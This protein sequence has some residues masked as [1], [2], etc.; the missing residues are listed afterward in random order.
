MDELVYRW[1]LENESILTR[2]QRPVCINPSFELTTLIY[3]RLFRGGDAR[4]DAGIA[5]AS[6]GVK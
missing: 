2:V 3:P 6:T 4:K 1:Y 5:T